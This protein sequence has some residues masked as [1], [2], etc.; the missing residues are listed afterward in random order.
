MST[1]W[2]SQVMLAPLCGTILACLLFKANNQPG[3]YSLDATHCV[4]LCAAAFL[5]HTVV[6]VLLLLHFVP[7][8]GKEAPN[9][10]ECDR[11]VPYSK[12]GQDVAASYF[13]TNPI[14]CLRSKLIYKHSPPCVFWE[15]G[16][17]HL[18]KVNKNIGCHFSCDK[19]APESVNAK[20]KV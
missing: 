18:L 3:Y 17:E 19:L 7:M 15:S 2:W 1:D 20:D 12:V 4:L 5:V 14:H 11:R 13:S 9:E 10:D 6:H 16:K 8:L